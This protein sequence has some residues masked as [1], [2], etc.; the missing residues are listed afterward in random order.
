MISV[1]ICTTIFN[2]ALGLHKLVAQIS[3][4]AVSQVSKPAGARLLQSNCRFGN[5]R[6]SRVGSLRYLVAALTALCSSVVLLKGL[7]DPGVVVA[8]TR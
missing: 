5:R 1:S 8:W 4:S 3:K 2:S 6:H 7:T